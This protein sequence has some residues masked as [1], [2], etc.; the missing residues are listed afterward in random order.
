MVKSNLLKKEHLKEEVGQAKRGT[1]TRLIEK[2]TER[3]PQKSVGPSLERHWHWNDEL[4]GV[5]NGRLLHIHLDRYVLTVLIDSCKL[6]NNRLYYIRLFYN[7][8]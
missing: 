2:R 1:G 7:S 6:H 8:I 5:L 3:T 4:W